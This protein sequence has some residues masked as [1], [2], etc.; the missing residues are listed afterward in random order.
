MFPAFFANQSCVT[1]IDGAILSFMN[2]EAAV[3]CIFEEYHTLL[4]S[5][6][7]ATPK[8]MILGVFPSACS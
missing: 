6:T 3:V 2:Y 4:L 1:F 7:S 8:D 5:L